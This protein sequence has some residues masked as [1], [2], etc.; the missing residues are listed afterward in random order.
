MQETVS[1]MRNVPTR[2]SNAHFCLLYIL[3]VFKFNLKINRKMTTDVWTISRYDSN[4]KACIQYKGA[5]LYK[6]INRIVAAV[7]KLMYVF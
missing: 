1:R 5:L 2:P 6:Y 3:N 4:D 7:R